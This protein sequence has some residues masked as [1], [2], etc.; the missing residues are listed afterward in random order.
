MSAACRL[1]I[2]AI[3]AIV[4]SAIF[5]AQ[6][7]AQRVAIV[8]ADTDFNISDVHAKLTAAGVTDVTVVNA[9][10]QT[11]T[12]E[13]LQQFDA[14]LTWA[15][16]AFQSS[17]TL[18]NVLADY[19]DGGGGVVEG[20]LVFMPNPAVRLGGRWLTSGYDVFTTGALAMAPALALV[21][22][23][24]AHPILAGVTTFSGGSQ[25]FHHTLAVQ[26]CGDLVAQW[27]N[28]RPLVAARTG[29]LGGRIIGLNFYPVSSDANFGF[30]DSS[31][32]G[33][34]LIANALRFAATDAPPP[35]STSNGPAVALIAADDASRVTDVRCKLE[36]TGLFSR[37]DGIDARV[38][39]P[40]LAQLADYSAVLTW[41][42]G[43][44][45]DASALG[46]TLADFAD[47]NKGVVQSVVNVTPAAGGALNG[48]WVT[49]GYRPFT[50]GSLTGGTRQHLVAN[51]PSHVILSG[52]ADV[53]GGSLSQHASAV[54]LESAPSLV[55][56]WDVDA[57]P[58]VATGLAAAG[59]RIVGLNMYPPSA[60]AAPG[61]W[62]SAT[63]GARLIANALLFAANRFPSANAGA[64]Q[65]S[66]AA[67]SAGATFTLQ[68]NGS[69]PDG[70][71]LSFAW[72]GAGNVPGQ[73]VIVDIP[74]PPA[75]QKSHTVS[76]VLTVADGKGGEA[77]DIV[78]VT[79]TD[80]TAPVLHNMPS[81]ML[82]AAATSS[83]GAS[84]PYGP[85][86]AT[87]AV[88]GGAPASCSHA[89]VFPVGDTVVTCSASDSRD[90][91]VAESFVVR[92]TAAPPSSTPGRMHGAG[93]VG[94]QGRRRAFA[95][96]V[97]ET[98]AGSEHAI[99]AFQMD[100]GHFI[101]VSVETVVFSGNTVLFTGT[102]RRNGIGG[103]R[104][105]LFA[106][107]NGEPG[108]VDQVRV[109]ITTPSGATEIAEGQVGGGNIQLL[110]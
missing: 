49:G 21:A 12:L 38:G 29:P 7:Y 40:A 83:S 95:F 96:T 41:S 84:V 89:G 82:T 85:V 3:L 37:V 71:V 101:G 13:D 14:V 86:T 98:A 9:S 52:V 109:V 5:P 42:N 48:R 55:A 28:G 78:D 74:P 88:D 93:F 32:D 23:N 72:T 66:E 27:T 106:A 4:F 76:V 1:V 79:V 63:D 108:R 59:G 99:L 65:A 56:S 2:G 73:N 16:M 80:T 104:Y 6:V 20:A 100:R 51:A 105:E 10:A 62:E 67:T 15:S 53:D 31:T 61:S 60:A 35:P 75:P 47:Q 26:G 24:P 94:G 50:E 45:A 69:D 33:A 44:Y 18:G 58:F 77:T 68:G 107:D 102:G 34:V 92:V 17:A 11:P 22:I 97:R 39:T 19:V 8:A 57:Q 46:T 87:D 70:D 91:T 43:S 81:G 25:G 90:N 64:D 54:A 30:W 36:Q 110:R 103:F